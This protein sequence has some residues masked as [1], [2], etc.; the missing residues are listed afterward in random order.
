MG[1]RGSH[2]VPVFDIHDPMGLSTCKFPRTV[3]PVKSRFTRILVGR[4][5]ARIGSAEPA[6]PLGVDSAS[7]PHPPKRAPAPSLPALRCAARADDL[8]R[9]FRTID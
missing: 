2:S 7:N 3:G 5:L 6:A 8:P 9:G 1:L 4:D